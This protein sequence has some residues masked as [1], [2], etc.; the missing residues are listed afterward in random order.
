MFVP[1]II[2]YLFLFIIF[3]DLII[4]IKWIKSDFRSWNEKRLLKPKIKLASIPTEAEI[5]KA[6]LKALLINYKSDA[7][8]YCLKNHK[9]NNYSDYIEFR[10]MHRAFDIALSLIEYKF[11][12]G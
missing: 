4:S 10:G 6:D 12:K 7:E 9:E 3:I 11:Q 2:V 5:K 8:K 1:T